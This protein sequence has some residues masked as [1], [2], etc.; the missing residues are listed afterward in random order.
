MIVANYAFK[1]EPYVVY[2]DELYHCMARKVGTVWW[3]VSQHGGGNRTRN[4]IFSELHW[5]VLSRKTARYVKWG[6]R[7]VVSE[8]IV[9]LRT[10]GRNAIVILYDL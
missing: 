5:E 7:V 2:R 9:T 1:I 10:A 3:N 8:E 6:V 4:F